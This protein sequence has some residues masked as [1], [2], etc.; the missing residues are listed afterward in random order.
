MKQR[1]AAIFVTIAV[2]GCAARTGV[3]PSVSTPGPQGLGL[4]HVVAAIPAFD[5]ES[6]MRDANSAP[7]FALTGTVVDLESGQPLASSEIIVRRASDGK[8]VST[9]TDG[10]GGFMVPRIPPGLY[11]LI[12]RRVGYESV[13]DL[14]DARAGAIDTLRLKM[15]QT[16]NRVQGTRGGRSA[17]FRY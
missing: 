14:R 8:I 13:A 1:L 16:E 7:M 4:V 12:V 11:G 9:L 17:A 6:A 10:R 2:T 3:A 5:A 15:L